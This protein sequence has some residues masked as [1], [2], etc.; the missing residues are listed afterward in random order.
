M[1]FENKMICAHDAV[2]KEI[3]KLNLIN[4]VQE[5]N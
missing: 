1:N 5:K 3:L 4:I 2:E